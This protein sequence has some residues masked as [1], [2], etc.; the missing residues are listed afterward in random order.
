MVAVSRRSMLAAVAA[1]GAV[2][3][4]PGCAAPFVDTRLRLATGSARG[5]YFR[6]GTA[7]AQAWQAELALTTTPVV[8]N[9]AGSV[10]NVDLLAAGD[11]DVAFSQVD[12]AAEQLVDTTPDSPA[13]PRALARIYDDVLHVVVPASSPFTSLPGLRGA[14]VSVGAADSGVSVVAQRLL[15]A[16]NL[17][18]ADLRGVPLGLDDSVAAM[19]AGEIDAF[20]WSG[21]LPTPAVT[22]L[23]QQLP[24][25]LLDLTEDGVLDAVRERYPVYAPGTVPALSYTGIAT[26]ITTMLVRNFLLVDA[27]M[28][29]DLAEALVTVLF[30]E[31]EQLAQAGP[32]ALT[33]DPRAAIGTEPVLLHPG[34]ER[35]YRTERG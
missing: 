1:A 12:A 31:Q 30:T 9:T 13:A 32:A 26:P 3:A 16:A 24:I 28:P 27:A 25:R 5:V 22:E 6:L 17:G 8:L 18:E 4:L 29:D 15:D 10:E 2:A 34:A 23:A 11:A 19:A 33:I 14:R 35:F 21:G 7:L 20:F